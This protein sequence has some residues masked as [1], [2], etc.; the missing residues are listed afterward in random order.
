MATPLEGTTMYKLGKLPARKDAVKFKLSSYEKTALPKPPLTFGHQGLVNPWNMY[1]NDK[2]GDCVW[3]GAGHETLLWNKEVGKLVN[4]T[5]ANILASYTAVT[6]FNPKD[7]NTDQG[8]DMELAAKYRRQTGLKDKNGTVHKVGA[9]LAIE[10]GDVDQI[11]Q[12]VYLY[13]AVGIGIQ[14]PGSAMDQFNAGKPWDVVK[15]AKI[16]GG[17]YVPVV[18]FDQNY[19]YVVTWGELQP[20]TYAFIKKYM[21]EGIAYLS[22]EF[23]SKTGKT[24]D[25]FDITAL[26]NDLKS[27]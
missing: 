11:K 22:T 24:L 5:D 20:V 1:G 21:D 3:A 17:H 12:A 8:T 15:G 10:T 2:Y 19:V 18:G 7:P 25:G 14:F 26:T 9:Y 27:L 16:E 23:I 4:F 13:S 6:G